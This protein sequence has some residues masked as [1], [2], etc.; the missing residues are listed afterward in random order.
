MTSMPP[1]RP[2]PPEPE[3]GWRDYLPRPKV[4]AAA[5]TVLVAFGLLTFGRLLGIDLLEDLDVGDLLALLAG[6]GVAVTAAYAK[7]DS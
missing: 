4:T 7:D 6:G 1:P 5:L 2:L 3:P